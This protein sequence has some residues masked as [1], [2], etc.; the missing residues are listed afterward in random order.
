MKTWK[1][2]EVVEL[3]INETAWGIVPSDKERGFFIGTHDATPG[4]SE[5]IPGGSEETKG[6][7]NN[8]TPDTLS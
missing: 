5:T 4:G 2:A 1:N 6:P 8:S 3:N 7:D